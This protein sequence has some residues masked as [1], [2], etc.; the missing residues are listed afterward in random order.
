V[1]EK[2]LDV[3]SHARTPREVF[4]SLGSAVPGREPATVRQ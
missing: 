3:L 4:A 1:F 2:A